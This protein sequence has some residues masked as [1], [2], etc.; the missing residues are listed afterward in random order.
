MPQNAVDRPVS[1]RFYFLNAITITSTLETISHVHA[2]A[3]RDLDGPFK[4]WFSRLAAGV[5]S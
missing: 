1:F 5:L 2:M 3:D 4:G